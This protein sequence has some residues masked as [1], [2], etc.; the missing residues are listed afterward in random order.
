MKIMCPPGYHLNGFVGAHA[1]GHIMSGYK[2]CLYPY[3]TL[4]AWLGEHSLVH[5]Y[6][7]CVKTK[8]KLKNSQVTYIY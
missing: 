5:W 3:I 8:K 6:Q 2:L 1:L 4:L 7:Q